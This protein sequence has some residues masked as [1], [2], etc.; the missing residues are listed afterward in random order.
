MTAHVYA[1]AVEAAEGLAVAL[2]EDIRRRPDLVLALPTGA[3]PLPLYAALRRA[4]HEGPDLMVHLRTFNLDEFVGVPADDTASYRSYMNREL[5]HAAHLSARQIGFLDGCA[6]DLDEECRRY[7]QRIA[8]AGGIDVAVLGL[9]RNG[10]IGFNEPAE[11]L[12]AHTH[13]AVLDESTR[14]ANARWFGDAVSRAPRQ[15]LSMGV[16]IML[17][18]RRIML[19]ATGAAKAQAVA[20]LRSGVVTTRVPASLLQCHP[21]VTLWLDEDAA[22]F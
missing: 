5:F 21:D 11:M 8:Q 1:T 6:E 2:I 15:A 20:Q 9:G 14:L 3:T 12:H 4:A 10:H 18:A 7:D 16:G 17:G 19:L 22:R 13:V